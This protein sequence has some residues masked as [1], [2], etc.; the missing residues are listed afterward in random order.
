ME[1]YKIQLSI[2]AKNDYKR[3]ISYLKNDLLEPSIAN[4][5]IEL[6]NSEIQNVEYFPQK[7]AIIDYDI[8]RKLEFR[9]L[10]IK[11]YIAFYK[12]NEREKIVEVHRILYGASDW[13]Y[14][15]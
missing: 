2:K 5:Y 4:K 13:M 1:K 14:E 9:K 8:V 11:N 6:I 7:H 15:L 12:I 3:I 10:I